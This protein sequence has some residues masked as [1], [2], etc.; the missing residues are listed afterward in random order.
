MPDLGIALD[1]VIDV[2]IPEPEAS[3][4]IADSEAMTPLTAPRGASKPPSI[5]HYANAKYRRIQSYIVE[6][7]TSRVNLLVA[8]IDNTSKGWNM[9][10]EFDVQE[11]D[12]PLLLRY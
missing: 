10:G 1:T 3:P 4:H 12:E 9:S 11:V 6:R 7:K 5:S 2:T 8:W